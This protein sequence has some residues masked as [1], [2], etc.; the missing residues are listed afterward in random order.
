MD[1]NKLKGTF[2][3]VEHDKGTAVVE[4]KHIDSKTK[5]DKY[6]YI[7][8]PADKNSSNAKI[9][10]LAK[11]EYLYRT[12]KHKSD[13]PDYRR[14]KVFKDKL[15]DGWTGLPRLSKKGKIVTCCCVIAL[16]GLATGGHFLA[17]YLLNKERPMVERI[18][19]KKITRE[20]ASESVKHYEFKL[21][22]SVN[23]SLKAKRLNFDGIMYSVDEEETTE[24]TPLTF[25]WD[26][27]HYDNVISFHDLAILQ[28]LDDTEINEGSDITVVPSEQGINDASSTSSIVSS[29][30]GVLNSGSV[31]NIANL[32]FRQNTSTIFDFITG[33]TEIA[34]ESGV[35]DIT[36]LEDNKKVGVVVDITDVKKFVEAFDGDRFNFEG[37]GTLSVGFQ[38]DENGFLSK[39][40]VVAKGDKLIYNSNTDHSAFDKFEGKLDV[41]L[42]ANMSHTSFAEENDINFWVNG[43]EIKEQENVSIAKQVYIDPIGFNIDPTE[44]DNWLY[45]VGEYTAYV[46]RTYFRLIDVA[47]GYIIDHT[48]TRFFINHVDVTDQCAGLCR[49][50]TIDNVKYYTVET[51][52][53]KTKE[54]VPYV[55]I[56]SN[57]INSG[58]EIIVSLLAQ[59]KTE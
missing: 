23:L 18:G 12:F 39:L 32:L 36:Y 49:T 44:P 2:T 33:Y 14:L 30:L 27:L 8:V 29:I 50:G 26:G 15:K 19:G 45:D 56:N 37:D 46:H 41:Y 17:S 1:K 25:N 28:G 38:I 55:Y 51:G 40:Y 22:N 6:D 7:G 58:D 21:A 3:V 53:W 13:K 20:A 31:T 59:A 34:E 10:E 35:A 48:N 4:Y 52:E 42:E 11:D 9:I 43:K 16:A 5:K 24:V 47:E 57:Y 54:N